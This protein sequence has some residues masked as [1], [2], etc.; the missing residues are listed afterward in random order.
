M[1]KWLFQ[2][3]IKLLMIREEKSKWPLVKTPVDVII[4][5]GWCLGVSPQQQVRVAAAVN[6]LESEEDQG[7]WRSLCK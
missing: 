6:T 3:L 1:G 4:I 7:E 5:E 2:D